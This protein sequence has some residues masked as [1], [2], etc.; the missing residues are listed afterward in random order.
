M[1]VFIAG[2]YANPSF[3]KGHITNYDYEVLVHELGHALGLKHPFEAHL[4]NTAKLSTYEDNTG[5]TAMSYDEDPATYNGTLR[6]LDW[7]AL[8]KFYGLNPTYNGGDDTYGF[9]T[10]GGI[11]ILDGGGTD[12]IAAQ[13]TLFNVTIDLRPGAH[14]YLGS[15]SDYI[16]AANQLTIS[17]GSNIENVV[18]GMGDD[19]VIGTDS[20]NFISTGI[21]WVPL[22]AV[23]ISDERKDEF[24]QAEVSCSPPYMKCFYIAQNSIEAFITEILIPLLTLVYNVK[25][26]K[27]SVKYLTLSKASKD[28]QVVEKATRFIALSYLNLGDS[29][30]ACAN[31]IQLLNRFPKRM[32]QQEFINY[33]RKK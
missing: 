27:N 26:Y 21:E 33:C 29:E 10:S 9:S 11:F 4:S 6:S 20:N 23:E 28:P 13:D 3:L 19:T 2:E 30:K 16:T 24:F 25:D 1:D 8:V 18:T 14:S 32:Y 22:N 31:F 15:K 17:H 5:N 12:T 7:M